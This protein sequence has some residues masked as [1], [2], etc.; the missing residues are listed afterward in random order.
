MN[1]RPD[2]SIIIL[3][4]NTADL[5]LQCLRSVYKTQWGK[6]TKE[7]FVVDNASADDTVKRIK[8]TYPEVLVLKNAKNVGFAAGNNV[9]IQKANG[10]YIL[11]LNSDTEVDTDAIPVMVAFMDSHPPAG[12]STCRVLLP[13]GSLDP[14][15]H[16]GFPTPWASLAYMSGLERLFPKSHLFGG[17]HLGYM[18]MDAAHEIDCPSG[19]FFLVRREVIDSVGMLD[20]DFFMYGEDIDWAYRIKEKGW[21]IWFNPETSILHH[22]KQSGRAHGDKTRRIQSE[23]Y[24][25]TTMRLFYQKHYEKKYCRCITML[26]YLAIRI[27]LF[28][29]NMSF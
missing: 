26:V 29:L 14:A 17:Y 27:K 13:N 25:L 11:L 12:V 24:F 22:K 19:A 10:R 3:S 21:E 23:K 2:V 16:R 8:Q 1:G 15:S 6:V 20:E 4:Y 18:D 28:L 9:G 7:I 5:T